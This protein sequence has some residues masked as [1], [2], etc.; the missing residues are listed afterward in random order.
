MF[1]VAGDGKSSRTS[2]KRVEM[3]FG[4]GSSDTSSKLLLVA[5][6]KRVLQQAPSRVLKSL[7]RC[8]ES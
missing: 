4:N 2:P 6:P 7:N 8:L 3:T 1:V 5:S